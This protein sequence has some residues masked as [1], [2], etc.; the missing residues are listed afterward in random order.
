MASQMVEFPAILLVR[1]AYD[2]DEGVKMPE[3]LHY[4]FVCYANMERSPTAEA[5]C[6]RIAAENGLDIQASSA[7]TSDGAYRPLTK[8]IADLADKIFVME[9]HMVREM[10]EEFGQNPAK[11][12]C[13]DIPDMYERDDPELVRTLEQKLYEYMIRE[14]LI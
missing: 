5:V 12:I 10:V 14:G 1:L 13:L 4:L 7:G 2:D 6:R 8:R 11:I 9:P 3:R